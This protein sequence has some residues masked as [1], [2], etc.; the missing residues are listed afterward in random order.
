MPEPIRK[1]EPR[2]HEPAVPAAEPL[3]DEEERIGRVV[4]EAFYRGYRRAKL[5]LD[6]ER[7][8]AERQKSE[9]S[10]KNAPAETPR[11]KGFLR[12]VG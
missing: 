2:G 9:E 8:E 11:T 4:E 10:K 7:Q 5:D 6:K 12:L 1:P 3:G